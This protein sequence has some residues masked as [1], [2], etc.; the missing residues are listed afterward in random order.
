MRGL[1]ATCLAVL[2]ALLHPT[3][4]RPCAS[5]TV[6]ADN[7]IYHDTGN[8]PCTRRV[9]FGGEADCYYSLKRLK[10]GTGIVNM[11]AKGCSKQRR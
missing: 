4:P 9:T 5:E 10:S 6:N 3:G 11:E 2:V 7:G 1:R 8:G